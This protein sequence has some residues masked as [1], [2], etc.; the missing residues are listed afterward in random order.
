M[1]KNPPARY[2]LPDPPNPG[3]YKGVCVQIPDGQFHVAAFLGQVKALSSAYVWQDD[4]DHNALL[5]ADAWKPSFETVSVDRPGCGIFPPGILCISGSFVDGEYGVVPGISAPC[6]PSWV[7]GT[8]WKSCFDSGSSHM[9]LDLLWLFDHQTFVRHFKLH[10][11]RTVLAGYSWSVDL[12]FA[13]SSVYHADN[14]VIGGGGDSFDF[15]INQQVD[16][17]VIS[18]VALD[19]STT[20]F[21]DLDDWEICYT[22]D[23]P[24]SQGV[25]VFT[26][27]FDFSVS[28]GSWSTETHPSFPNTGQYSSGRWESQGNINGAGKEDQV[29]IIHRTFSARTITSV[30]IEWN[31]GQSAG[32]GFRELIGK[33]SGSEVSH[34]VLASGAGSF[35]Q[36]YTPNALLD[37]LECVPTTEGTSGSTPINF[38]TKITVSGVGTDPF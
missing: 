26:H 4:P 32:A 35:V 15:D 27:V 37:E 22:G 36:L 19:G 24:L 33:H 30:V 12:L 34:L 9:T 2:T 20:E 11:V 14:T 7:S 31:A 3:T 17:I 8:G 16:A 5:A 25:D 28:D 23:F 18:A 13:G 10:F 21:I 1:R 29:L 38:V 6:S